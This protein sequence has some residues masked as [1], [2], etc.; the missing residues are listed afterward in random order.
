MNKIE[1]VQWG[2]K[3]TDGSPEEGEDLRIKLF[4]YFF[5]TVA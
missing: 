1:D 4:P 2:P 5:S 3:V